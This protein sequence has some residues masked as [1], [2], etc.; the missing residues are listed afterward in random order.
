M[1][2]IIDTKSNGKHVE[3]TAE[4]YHKRREWSRSQIRVLLQ[5]PTLFHG[6]FIAGVFEEQRTAAK[7]IGIITHECLINPHGFDDVCAIIPPEVLNA[8]GH[9]KGKPYTDWKREHAGLIDLKSDEAFPVFCMT[10]NVREHPKARYLLETATDREYT[11]V[12]TDPETH[13][14]LRARPDM[15]CRDGNHVILVDIK[16]TSAV[17]PYEFYQHTLRY[18]YHQQAAW[19]WEATEA[20]GWQVNAFMFVSVDK[21]PAFECNVFELQKDLLNQGRA[22]VAAARRDLKE[23]LRTKNWRSPTWGKV[24]PLDVF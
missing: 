9:R 16:T 13:L 10:R 23:R 17:T 19:Y 24:L 3:C 1:A 8:H 6:R 11:I 18:G 12:W 15:I 2:T 20:M 4:Q 21:S 5:S 7:D 14:K 22:E